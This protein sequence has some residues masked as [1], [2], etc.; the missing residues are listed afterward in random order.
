MFLQNDDQYASAPR[1]EDHLF[2]ERTIPPAPDGAFNG[3][4]GHQSLSSMQ[5]RHTDSYMMVDCH[6]ERHEQG[7]YNQMLGTT[8][9]VP[10]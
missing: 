7:N 3:F 2:H 4:S 9:I 10:D 1:C 6:V 8:G 5:K